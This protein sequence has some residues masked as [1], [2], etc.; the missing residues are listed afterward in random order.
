MKIVVA[1][2]SGLPIFMK[3][4]LELLMMCIIGSDLTMFRSTMKLKI[5]RVTTSAVNK[6]A[7]TPMVSV[8]PKPLISPVPMKIR[9]MDEISVVT[10]ESKIVPKAR[11]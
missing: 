2:A 6:L 11:A 7:A 5:N 8:T 4:T 1:S 10:C 9:M 3:S